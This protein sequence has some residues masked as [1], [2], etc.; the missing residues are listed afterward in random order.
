MSAIRERWKKQRV[1][2]ICLGVLCFWLTIG[3]KVPIFWAEMGC[4]Q[5]VRDSHYFVEITIIEGRR[6]VVLVVYTYSK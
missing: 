5:V 4:S 2:C 3:W 6:A 1:I